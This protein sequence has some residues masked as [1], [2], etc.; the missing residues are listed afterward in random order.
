MLQR[1]IQFL[2]PWWPQPLNCFYSYFITVIFATVMNRNVLS[3]L[4]QPLWKDHSSPQRVDTTH[5]LRT[6]VKFPCQKNGISLAGWR[7]AFWSASRIRTL[8][9]YC[10]LP[11][12]NPAGPVNHLAAVRYQGIHLKTCKEEGK[13]NPLNE[14]MHLPFP[15]T[16]FRVADWKSSVT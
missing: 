16:P 12:V 13:N 3:S 9:T 14:L 2:M 11:W 8:Y 7:Q 15:E 1:F 4:R 5:R 10:F 6:T